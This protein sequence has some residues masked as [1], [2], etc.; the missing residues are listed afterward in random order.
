MSSFYRD[1]LLFRQHERRALQWFV[2]L[3]FCIIIFPTLYRM[4]VPPRPF[5]YSLSPAEKQWVDHHAS[6]TYISNKEK[7]NPYFLFDPNT[8]SYDSLM[9]LGLTEKQ[10]ALMIKLRKKGK[11]FHSPA[12]WLAY[13]Y[14]STYRKKALL[15]W[16]SIDT[17]NPE[18]PLSEQNPFRKKYRTQTLIDINQMD[19][20]ALEQLPGIGPKLSQRI[21][22]YRE[23]LGGFYSIEQLQEVWGLPDST[24]QKIKTRLFADSSVIEAADVHS[25][26]EEQL[27]Y[28]PYIGNRRAGIIIR[29]RKQEAGRRAKSWTDIIPD[30]TDSTERKLSIYFRLTK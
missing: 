3:L 16:L 12:D 9:T 18:K 26:A 28:H 13:P 10:A 4:L 22:R 20:A 23:K 24:Y 1:W 29:Y 21:I 25:V 5:S 15:P 7:N 6:H 27:K 2:L 30:I 17:T 14:L 8:I 19:S 11:P